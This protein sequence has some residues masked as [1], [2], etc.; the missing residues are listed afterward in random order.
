MRNSISG[1]DHVVILVRDLDRAADTYTRLGFTLTPRGY[2]TLGSQNHCLMFG[3]DYIELLAVPKPHPVMAYFSDFLS[4]AEGLGAIAF[5]TGDAHALHAGL[6]ADGIA[7]DAPVDFSRPVELPGGARDARFR[8]V[9]LPE[10]A[11]PGCRTFA[12]QHFDR[13]V[14]WLPEATRHALGVTAIAAVAVVADDVAATAGAYAQVLAEQPTSIPE[15]KLIA[16]G[17]A[18]IAV[19]DAARLGNR[20]AGVNLP[21][22]AAPQLAALFLRVASRTSAAAVLKRGG[23]KPRRLADGAL[24]IDADQAH[25]VALILG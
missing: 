16:T 14:V 12:C 7:A 20:L 8:V 5:A 17:G 6:T 11:T 19:S 21:S 24:A 22:R 23:F 13:D 9:Q 2:H 4:R 10:S 18:P 3:S 1:I 25:G 15:G